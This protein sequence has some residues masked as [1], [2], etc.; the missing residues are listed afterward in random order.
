MLQV[1]VELI[2]QQSQIFLDF[3][4]SLI[5]AK[6]NGE[7]KRLDFLSRLLLQFPPFVTESF[8]VATTAAEVLL[9]YF[10]GPCKFTGSGFFTATIQPRSHRCHTCVHLA[11]NNST[12]LTKRFIVGI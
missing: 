4:E 1:A 6:V 5:R 2:R 10:P 11:E 3:L 8:H 9:M 7:S 12:L